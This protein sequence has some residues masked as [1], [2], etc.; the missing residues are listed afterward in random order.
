MISGSIPVSDLSLCQKILNHP[1]WPNRVKSTSLMHVSSFGKPLGLIYGCGED[2][3]RAK[4][5]TNTALNYIGFH[6]F[7]KLEELV[8]PQ[9]SALLSNLRCLDGSGSSDGADDGI[10]KRALWCPKRKLHYFVFSTVWTILV[11]PKRPKDE[12]TI[13]QMMQSVNDGSRALKLREPVWT[14]RCN[15]I[16]EL[17]GPLVRLYVWCKGSYGIYESVKVQQKSRK[18][19]RLLVQTP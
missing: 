16:A 13:S 18:F 2:Y 19:S 10:Q 3:K 15:R 9:V 1:A 14:F 11:G 17:V 5:M 7:V 6:N 12:T 4:R 8:A